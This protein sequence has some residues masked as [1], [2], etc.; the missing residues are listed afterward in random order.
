MTGWD[1][2]AYAGIP[3]GAAA[4]CF[5]AG[6]GPRVCGSPGEC[7]TRMVGERVRVFDVIQERAAAGDPVWRDIAGEFTE[8]GQLLDATAPAPSAEFARAQAKAAETGEAVGQCPECGSFTATGEPPAL[9]RYGCSRECPGPPA[10]RA[11][12]KACERCGG[13]GGHRP[14]CD[15]LANDS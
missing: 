7:T 2:E 15:L 3:G 10:E 13:F 5:F 14:I 11:E 8:P 4:M 9:H 12:V 1:C 6:D